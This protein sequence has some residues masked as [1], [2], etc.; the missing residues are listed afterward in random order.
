M[1]AIDKR[2]DIVEGVSA[3][4]IPADILCATE[5]LLLKGLVADWPFVH[6]GSQNPAAAKDY[7]LRFYRDAQVLALRGAAEHKGRFFYDETLTGFNFTRTNS[8]LAAILD[9]LDTTPEP[10]DHL[11]VGSTA[12][13]NCL[14]GFRSSNDLALQHLNPLVSIWLGNRSRI[15]A[16]YDFPDNIACVVAGRRRFTLFP[17]EQLPNLYVGPLDVTP[18]GQPISLVDF[19]QPDRQRF[20]RFSAALE[21]ALIAELQPGDALFLPSMWWHHVEALENFNVLINYWWRSTAA[22]TGTPADALLHGVMALRNLPAA[23]K[24]AWKGIF[25]H[26]VFNESPEALAHIPA[27]ALGVLGEP[28]ADKS[29]QLRAMLRNNLNR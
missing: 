4:A 5:P 18:A 14:P 27:A 10:A 16:H 2:V 26:Y 15:A 24:R 17:P 8:S 22:F 1:L 3:N 7:L 21:H 13:D 19:H 11:Y 28:D 25:E 20:P 29:R 12:V 23:Q 9:E 6:A